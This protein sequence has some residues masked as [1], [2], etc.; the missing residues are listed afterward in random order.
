MYYFHQLLSQTNRISLRDKDYPVESI[1]NDEY[2]Q[3]IFMFQ[4]HIIHYLFANSIRIYTLNNGRRQ[5]RKLGRMELLTLCFIR[6]KQYHFPVP[7][8]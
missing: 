2:R 3:T 4:F 8:L 6:E 5:L 1:G 7:F